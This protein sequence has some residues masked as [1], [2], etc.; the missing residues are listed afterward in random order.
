MRPASRVATSLCEKGDSRTRPTTDS[1][2]AIRVAI[3]QDVGETC[4][5]RRQEGGRGWKGRTWPEDGREKEWAESGVTHEKR[6]L[7]CVDPVDWRLRSQH[8]LPSDADQTSQNRSYGLSFCRYVSP[9]SSPFL[10]LMHN[11]FT[12]KSTLTAQY[13]EGRTIDFYDPT[14]ENSE[15]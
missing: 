5:M 10:A 7:T 1:P 2:S 15:S 3:Y 13:V 6:S 14:I 4:S 11:R 9:F 8:A 12:G